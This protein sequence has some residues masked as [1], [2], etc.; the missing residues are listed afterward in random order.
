MLLDGL[1]TPRNNNSLC[2][3]LVSKSTKHA[4]RLENTQWPISSA[5]I[6][7]FHNYNMTRLELYSSLDG[8]KSLVHGRVPGVGLA[9]SL[10]FTA[11][12]GRQ[13]SER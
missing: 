3:S 11:K 8:C 4:V 6:Y 1:K 7:G 9:H 12:R 10:K 13:C 2:S 5:L